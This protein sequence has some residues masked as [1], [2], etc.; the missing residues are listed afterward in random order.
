MLPVIGIS[1]NFLTVDSG[2][3]LGMERIYVNK[4]YVQAVEKSGGLPLLLPPVSVSESVKEYVRLCDGFIFSGGGDINPLLFH[5]SPHPQLGEVNTALDE[6]QLLLIHE[7][8]KSG[9]PVLAICRGVQLLNVALGGTL[10]QDMSEIET[11]AHLHSQICPRMEKIHEVTIDPESVTGRLFGKCI[12]VNSFHHQSIKKLGRDLQVVATAPDGII[13]AV[14]MKGKPFIV[15]IQWH[16]EM[17]LQA[18]DEMLPL[19]QELIRHSV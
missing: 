19:F 6:A 18:D 13:E 14:E 5:C 8:L 3:F 7:V 11:P 15:G 4:D 2:K 17:L 1:T 9:K 12:K 16:P 10:Y